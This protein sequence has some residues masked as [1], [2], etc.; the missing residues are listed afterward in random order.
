MDSPQGDS[1][2]QPRRILVLT[3]LVGS[4]KSTFAECLTSHYPE[5]YKRA[6][7]D[8]LGSRGAVESYVLRQLHQGYDVLIDRTNVDAQQ[9]AHWLKLAKQFQDSPTGCCVE[10]YSVYFA[11]PYEECK[12]RLE[13]RTTHET[14][15]SPHEAIKVLNIFSRQLVVPQPREGFH[16]LISVLPAESGSTKQHTDA[17]LYKLN[18]APYAPGMNA[19]KP[20]QGAVAQSHAPH[21]GPGHRTTARPGRGK[22]DWS[23]RA[24]GRGDGMGVAW[25][26]PAPWASTAEQTP[27]LNA[28]GSAIH[29]SRQFHSGY[30]R[31]GHN[32]NGASLSAA[33][34]NAGESVASTRGSPPPR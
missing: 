29:D 14:L 33:G 7:Q 28:Y 17:L 18:T 25:G 32:D 10:V 2:A 8:V 19:G 23:S 4:G 15:H 34:E 11:T 13:V 20:T 24:S 9:R 16:K 26:R 31:Q 30:A 3:G 12:S 21:G 22:L 5:V 1:C 6:S 27:A